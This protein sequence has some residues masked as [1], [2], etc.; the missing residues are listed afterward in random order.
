[1][2]RHLTC[3]SYRLENRGN[4]PFVTRTTTTD[5]RRT[6]ENATIKNLVPKRNHDDKSFFSPGSNDDGQR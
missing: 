2:K 3:D 5:G 1:M 6:D 4:F